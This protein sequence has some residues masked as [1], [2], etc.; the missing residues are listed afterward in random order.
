MSEIPQHI[1]LAVKKNDRAA[2]KQLYYLSKDRLKQIAI[3]YCPSIQDAKDAVQESYLKIFRA[4]N[5]FDPTRGSFEAWSTKI[6]VNASYAILRKKLNMQAYIN[7]T[8]IKERVS[9]TTL[10]RITIAEVR[11]ILHK[12]KLD[13]QLVLNM[14][15]FE[16]YSYREMS[17]ILEIKEASVRS[18]VSRAKTEL[19]RFWSDQN[20]VNYEAK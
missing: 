18:K 16:E 15:F 10:D 17:E 3:R 6:V 11:A 2:Q 5:T 14:Y 8:K 20:K 9:D 7:S 1:I 4:I 12:L 19:S 13:H